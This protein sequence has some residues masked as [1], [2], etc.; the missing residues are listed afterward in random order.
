VAKQH[1]N[2][3]TDVCLIAL[4]CF[5]LGTVEFPGILSGAQIFEN[6]DLRHVEFV[7]RRFF[8][9]ALRTGEFPAFFPNAGLGLSLFANPHY[10]VLYPSNLLVLAWN[11]LVYGLHVDHFVH[12]GVLGA[13][14]A[15][16]VFAMGLD[17]RAAWFTSIAL[18]ASGIVWSSHYRV[19]MA[20]MAWTGWMIWAVLNFKNTQSKT[21]AFVYAVASGLFVAWMFLGGNPEL[22][23]FTGISALW[24][25]NILQTPWPADQPRKFHLMKAAFAGA[26]ISLAICAPI[27]WVS[28]DVVP[29]TVRAAGF[30]LKTIFQHGQSPGS[31]F[32]FLTSIRRDVVEDPKWLANLGAGFDR[33]WYLD[34]RVGVFPVIAFLVGLRQM[35]SRYRTAAGL[36]TLCLLLLALT[37]FVPVMETIWRHFD[38]IRMFRYT[39]KFFRYAYLSMIPLIAFGMHHMVKALDARGLA[40]ARICWLLTIAT[41]FQLIENRPAPNLLPANHV[42][43]DRAGYAKAFVEKNKARSSDGPARVLSCM[44]DDAHAPGIEIP[45]VDFR[46]TG[47]AMAKGWDAAEIPMIRAFDCDW[48]DSWFILR[49]FGITHVVRPG[50]I[51]FSGLGSLA[52]TIPPSFPA[53]AEHYIPSDQRIWADHE[54]SVF[55]IPR[56]GPRIGHVLHDIRLIPYEK[57]RRIEPDDDYNLDFPE[58]LDAIKSGLVTIDSDFALGEDGR[59][60]HIQRLTREIWPQ[61]PGSKKIEPVTLDV[62]PLSQSIVANPSS[63]SSGF[64]VLPWVATPGWR[65]RVDGVPVPVYRANQSLMA[66]WLNPGKHKIRLDFWPEGLGTLIMVSVATQF[67]VTCLLIYQAMKHGIKNIH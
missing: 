33:P 63:S 13:G 27:L 29:L 11:D 53:A 48:M 40:G 16:A 31:L 64:L 61:K 41:V 8:L 18:C 60:S 30:N 62:G 14:W 3:V 65:A 56:S 21:H 55:A 1:F 57:V 4:V 52:A 67:A 49:L 54:K 51:V 35:S 25:M 20:S 32:E 44:K 7:Y 39:G 24:A 36:L 5:L 43:T 38:F 17:R 2:P 9:D 37:P 50:G 66:M 45:W 58:T 10:K 26:L 22:I 28:R 23:L 19:E 34:S 42:D 12:Y 46:A 6:H 59:P 15:S 47:I